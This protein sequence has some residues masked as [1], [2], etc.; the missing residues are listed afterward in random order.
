MPCHGIFLVYSFSIWK[1]LDDVA[2]YSMTW[3]GIFCH[4]T[5]IFFRINNGLL[6]LNMGLANRV[7][8][9]SLM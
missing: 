3:H 9:C 5:Y 6:T 8:E 1:I 7:L 4:I 2:K